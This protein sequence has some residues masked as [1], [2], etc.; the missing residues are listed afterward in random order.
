MI[1]VLSARPLT[2]VQDEGRSGYAALGVPRSGSF[3]RASAA[4]ANRL[5][6]NPTSAAV[7]EVTLGGLILRCTDALT[8]ALT[9]ADC[10]GIDHATPVS[11]SAGT[12]IRL[13]SPRHGLRSYLAVR[14]GVIVEPVLGS[15]STD[16][17]SGL[18]PRPIRAGDILA[19]GP[20]PH[21]PV[22]SVAA[23]RVPAP[24]RVLPGPR[25]DWFAASTFDQLCS[26]QWHVLTDSDRI[27][28]RLGGATL[29]RIRDGELPSEAT[30]PGA[31]QVPPDGRPIILGPDAPVTGGYPVI[32]VLA[33]L[34][35]AAQ[36]RP[37]DPV[38]LEG[39]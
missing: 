30:R 2:T 39:G 35:A 3:D 27:G 37:G 26:T 8:L 31:I 1:E 13:G 34:D 22:S 16:L 15:C 10:T 12:V 5:V 25:L 24:F 4:L 11:L 18:G 17:L 38:Q 32:A 33:D 14:G 6:G 21:A 29:S 23:A 7:L 9:G 28:V 19:I 36:L 20:Q